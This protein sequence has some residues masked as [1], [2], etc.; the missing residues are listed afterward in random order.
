MF[1]VPSKI[2]FKLS[3]LREHLG[4]FWTDWS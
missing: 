2:A 1:I 3:R 4:G